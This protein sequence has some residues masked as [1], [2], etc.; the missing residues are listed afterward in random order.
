MLQNIM[1]VAVPKADK[2][3]LTDAHIIKPSLNNE[4]QKSFALH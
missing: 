1:K 4:P 2:K 3:S